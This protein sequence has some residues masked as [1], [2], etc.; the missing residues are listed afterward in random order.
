MLTREET[1][2]GDIVVFGA[3][4]GE[5]TIG[6][7]VRR[8]PVNAV[9]AQLETRGTKK[10]RPVG[11]KWNCKYRGL[12]FATEEE[13]ERVRDKGKTPGS[14]REVPSQIPER[15]SSALPPMPPSKGKP[16]PKVL[17]P[18]VISDGN[19]LNGSA[20]PRILELAQ[21]LVGKSIAQIGYID[22]DGVKYPI[23]VLDDGTELVAQMDDEDNGPGALTFGSEM[24]CQVW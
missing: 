15:K 3:K 4:N 24:L 6:E 19:K 17:N 5:K 10:S 22:E 8:N 1:K 20:M 7:I 12:R 11:T 9:V 2:V 16:E 18:R 21:T 23:I 13:A 14:D